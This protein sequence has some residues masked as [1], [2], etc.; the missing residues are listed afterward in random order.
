MNTII[1]RRPKTDEALFREG[2]LA[3]L[4][5]MREMRS[6]PKVIRRDFASPEESLGDSVGIRQQ[7]IARAIEA[8]GDFSARQ[9]GFVSAFVEVAWTLAAGCVPE[10]GWKPE[11][12]MT[13]D[14]LAEER[15]ETLAIMRDGWE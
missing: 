1:C 11:C 4:D 12:A 3:A 7:A 14:E 8:A 2:A 6:T 15:A 9:R 5:V 10:D 13:P